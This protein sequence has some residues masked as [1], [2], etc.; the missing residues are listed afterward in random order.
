MQSAYSQNVTGRILIEFVYKLIVH[1][2]F[3]SEYNASYETLSVIIKS[4]EE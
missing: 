2:R 3:V 1:L 4:A